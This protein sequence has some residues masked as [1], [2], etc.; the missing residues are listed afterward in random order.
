MILQ[1]VEPWVP[2]FKEKRRNVLNNKTKL[3]IYFQSI[4][5][6]KQTIVFLILSSLNPVFLP[7]L[8]RN[9]FSPFHLNSRLA[10]KQMTSS[11]VALLLNHLWLL[12]LHLAIWTS[13]PSSLPPSSSPFSGKSSGIISLHLMPTICALVLENLIYSSLIFCWFISIIL[14]FIIVPYEEKGFTLWLIVMRGAWSSLFVICDFC[15]FQ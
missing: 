13:S 5:N 15:L 6:N 4:N 14:R 2:R 7:L 8:P 10:K 9:Q 1:F 12:K 3:M 11:W